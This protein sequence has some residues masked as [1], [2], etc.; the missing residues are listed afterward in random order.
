MVRNSPPS[1][2]D[3]NRAFFMRRANAA[4]VIGLLVATI[5]AIVLLIAIPSWPETP[6]GLFH[7][8]RV[9]AL[10]EALRAGVLYPRWFPD[11]A[12]GY[13]HPIF[14]YYAPAFYYPPA[15]L[16]L[17]G[18]DPIAAV[19][20]CLAATYGLSGWAMF[21]MLQRFSVVP[22][23]SAISAIGPLAGAI[24]YLAFPYR[25]Y[26]YAIRG[27]LPE[28][29]AF[30]WPPLL[31]MG[32]AMVADADWSAPHRS[33]HSLVG[34]LLLALAMAGLI[35]TH[36]LTALM[37]VGAL[38]VLALI[39]ITSTARAFTKFAGLATGL[40]LGVLL[41]AW[42]TV[43]ALYETRWVG[44][45]TDPTAFGYLNHF[46]RFENL[47]QWSP[48]YQY[49]AAADPTVPLPG[50]VALIIT[51]G[52]AALVVA[53]AVRTRRLLV[54][55]LLL[56]VLSIWLT[57][58]SSSPIWHTMAGVMGKLQFPWRWQTMTGFALALV[59]CGLIDALQERF[60]RPLWTGITAAAMI[61]AAAGATFG[62]VD[63]KTAEYAGSDLTKEQM[64]AFDAKFGQIGA[65][66]TGEFLPRWVVEERWAI[67]REPT[68]PQAREPAI[69]VSVLPLERGY[70]ASAYQTDGQA[71]TLRLHQFYFPGWQTTIDDV[72]TPT[73]PSGDLGLLAVD[74]PPGEHRVQVAWVA[75]PATWV[76]Q[77]LSAVGWLFVLAILATAGWNGQSRRGLIVCWAAVGLLAVA[78]MT[79]WSE[80]SVES[81][82]VQA[83]FGVVRLESAIVP[84]ARA[85]SV[86]SITLAWTIQEPSEPLTAYLHVIN[87]RGAVVAQYDGPLAGDYTPSSRWQP[88]YLLESTF[89]VTLS[90]TTLPG[91]YSIL[92][93]IYPSGR[94]EQPVAPGGTDDPSVH[95]GTLEVVP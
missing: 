7:L 55:G 75:T 86:V 89:P 78:G 30:L 88:G 68:T 21:A 27:A 49:S 47:F 18:T 3:L 72:S 77:A 37:V 29:T 2:A 43:P 23:R 32:L 93:G 25:I 26:D 6:D 46:S 42:Y 11:F 14:N 15:L 76:G 44:I 83:D 9:R 38:G 10:R 33:S 34:L 85:G 12:F 81:G 74:V 36:N 16:Q 4:F 19:R 45:G 63:Y 69:D 82:P 90:E 58:G 39:V 62:A 67:G 50:Y 94:P 65:T 5:A 48:L 53:T 24:V 35:L 8:Q 28:F 20:L 84:S 22:S 54:A 87:D 1:G 80:T 95:I 31:G 17:L 71:A 60:R 61:V 52:L 79:G 57:T 59:V 40:A 51:L 13:G 66:W 73:Y 91:T 56:S 64:W 41:S 70:L 92:G